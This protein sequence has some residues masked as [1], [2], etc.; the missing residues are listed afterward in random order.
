MDWQLIEWGFLFYTHNQS[1][2]RPGMTHVS[3]A[4]NL[5]PFWHF[6]HKKSTYPSSLDRDLQRHCSF[7]HWQA[8]YSLL[9]EEKQD[10]AN[11]D[12]KI[13]SNDSQTRCM[14]LR[15]VYIFSVMV[16]RRELESKLFKYVMR[17]SSNKEQRKVNPLFPLLCF[18]TIKQEITPHYIQ[19]VSPEL[20]AMW[21]SGIY[22][23]F[24]LN[25]KHVG[26]FLVQYQ[27]GK[28]KKKIKQTL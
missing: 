1:Y 22:T 6:H 11:N 19:H 15:E 18:L 4:V 23:H 26:A 3:G 5:G 20:D 8:V 24:R 16:A 27:K 7:H 9:G 17:L 21:D 12:S 2:W 13:N 10:K 25:Y 14:H 28:Q